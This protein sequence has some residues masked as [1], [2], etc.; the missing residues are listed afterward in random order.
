MSSLVDKLH[1]LQ[2]RAPRGMVLG[3][4][5]VEDALAALGNPHRD[6]LAVHVAG[7][8]GKGSTSAMVESVARA[9]GLRTGLYTS[10]HLSRFAERIRIDGVPIADAPFERALGAVLDRCRPDLTFFESITV[11]AFQAFREANL[12]VVVL[13][14]GLGGRLDA[15]NVI[16]RPVATAITSISL[17]HTAILGETLAAIAREKAGIFKPSAPVVLGPLPAEAE[18]AAVEMAEAVGAGPITRVGREIQVAFDGAATAIDGPGAGERVTATLRLAGAHQAENAGVAVGLVHHLLERFHDRDWQRA[19]E[20]GLSSA[21]WPGRLER[22]TRDD[23]VTVILD[24]AHNPEGMDRLARMSW[25]DPARTALVFGALADKRWPE[26]LRQIAPVASRRYYAEPKGRAP[27]PLAEL[28]QVAPGE[29]VAEPRAAI[30]RA[31]A[32]SRAGDVVLVTGSIYLVGE[33][34]SELLGIEA[35]PVIA[36]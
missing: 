14:V 15:T 33:V 25:G 31:L 16:E 34:R 1:A 5:R 36:L 2:A 13:E 9:A 12:D 27:A 19:L 11:A 32:E 35:D 17:E 30:R 18:Q 21:T 23:G 26:M 4:D 22:I 10:P 28:C 8:N 20:E 24:A 29:A 6:I 7:S 3:L